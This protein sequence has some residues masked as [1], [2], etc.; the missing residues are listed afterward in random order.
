MP[1]LASRKILLLKQIDATPSL[2]ENTKECDS[3]LSSDTKD[4]VSIADLQG[5]WQPHPS[6]AHQHIAFV[7]GGEPLWAECQVPLNACVIR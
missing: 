1:S 7:R 4:A 2:T 3:N 6:R 5:H